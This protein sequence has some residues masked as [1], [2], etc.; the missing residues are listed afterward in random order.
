MNQNHNGRETAVENRQSDPNGNLVSGEGQKEIVAQKGSQ[1][2]KQQWGAGTTAQWPSR[3]HGGYI[4]VWY[5]SYTAWWG[6]L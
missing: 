4:A 2:P 3:H 1:G 5:R 6:P